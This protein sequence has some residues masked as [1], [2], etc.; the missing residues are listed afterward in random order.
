MSAFFDAGLSHVSRTQS[1]GNFEA[2]RVDIVSSTNNT[3][4]S[5]T[6]LE[7]QFVLPVISAPFRLIF[8][9]NPLR[10]KDTFM[11][12]NSSYTLNEA[13]HDVKFTV[14]RSF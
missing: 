2:S 11:V 4:R 5:S 14:G 7:I 1:L 6:G 12:G 13:A 10:L 9:Y 3:L 8:A